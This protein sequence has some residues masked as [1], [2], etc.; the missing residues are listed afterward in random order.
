[1]KN[2]KYLLAGISVLIFIN[3]AAQVDTAAFK[4]FS[5]P[6]S[7]YHPGILKFDLI[8]LLIGQMDFTG[9]LRV[10]YERVIAKRQSIT[11]SGSYDFPNFILLAIDNSFGRRGHTSGNVNSVYINGG[12]VTFGY[13]YY[14]LKKSKVLNGLFAGPYLS[15]N[16]VKIQ[17]KNNSA[18]WN[19]VNYADASAILGYQKVFPKHWSFEFFGGFG[20]KDNFVLHPNTQADQFYDDYAF[21]RHSVI[22]HIKVV[23]QVNFG[24]AF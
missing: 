13:R 1:M 3:A 7:T 24:Y 12:R 8:P 5:A 6:K 21:L 18:E 22:S 19:V 11:V 16:A 10:T 15:Y 17:E 2:V 4:G 9:E 20:Y 14:P 23:M